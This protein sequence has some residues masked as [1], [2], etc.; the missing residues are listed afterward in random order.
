MSSESKNDKFKRIASVRTE[1]VLKKIKALSRCANT[2]SYNYTEN[3]VRKIFNADIGI[4]ITGV[5]GPDGGS[6]KKPVGFTCFSIDDGI[7]PYASTSKFFNDRRFNKEISAQT[8]LNS[9][10]LRLSGII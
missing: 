1:S 4:S 2:R 6:D 10:R 8:A 9:I 5:A 3:E 7:K